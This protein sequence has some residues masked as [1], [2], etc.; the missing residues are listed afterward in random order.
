MHRTGTP[1]ELG[2]DRARCQV[3]A[4]APLDPVRTPAGRAPVQRKVQ[5]YPWRAGC[6]QPTRSRAMVSA[7][8][9]DDDDVSS[10]EEQTMSS[11]TDVA[12]SGPAGLVSGPAALDLARELLSDV[13]TRWAHTRLAVDT[14][15]SIAHTVPEEDR[16]LLVA[17]AALH[18]VGYA[19]A[20]LRSGFHPLDGADHLAELGWPVRL[21]GLVAHHSGSRFTARARGLVDRLDAHPD[22]GG[23][24]ADALVYCDMTATPDGR[25]VRL[26]ERLQEMHARHRDDPAAERQARREREPFLRASVARVQARLGPGRRVIPAPTRHR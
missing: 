3:A 8:S 4:P 9:R 6:W 16:E 1:G 13:G 12:V 7:G 26:A 25:E 19:P 14:A 23:P 11:E 10:S 24:V 18:D 2:D 17:A 21:V 15:Y 20:L 5:G 22:E